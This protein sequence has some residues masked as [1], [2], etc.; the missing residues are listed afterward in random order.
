MEIKWYV[1]SDKKI[2]DIGD[3]DALFWDGEYWCPPSKNWNP[4]VLRESA[5]TT[6]A[7]LLGCAYLVEWDYYKENFPW[8]PTDFIEVP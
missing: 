8:D 4:A 3:H 1:V 2:L 7:L 6:T 5:A